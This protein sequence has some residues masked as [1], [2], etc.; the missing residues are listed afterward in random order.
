MTTWLIGQYHIWKAAVAGASI[1]DW[2]EEYNLSDMGGSFSHYFF[3][4]SPWVG[5]NMK[6]YLAQSPIAYATPI[7]T[8]TLIMSDTGDARVP[9]SQSYQLYHALKDN[10]VPVKFV[11]YPVPGHFP[12]DPVRYRDVYRRWLDW[13]D[14]YLK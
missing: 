11:A 13:L 7:K 12:D 5:G 8:P 3:K 9:I 2:N 10:G 4:G 1:T 14:Q 6:D